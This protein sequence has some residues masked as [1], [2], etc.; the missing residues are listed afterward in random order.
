VAILGRA[1]HA[2]PRD[3][4][5]HCE[6]LGAWWS[7][8]VENIAELPRIAAALCHGA[9]ESA[10]RMATDLRKWTEFQFRCSRG[11]SGLAWRNRVIPNGRVFPRSVIWAMVEMPI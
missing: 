5:R 7:A 3:S 1:R 8:G 10:R 6:A 11:H 9:A 4:G 2:G